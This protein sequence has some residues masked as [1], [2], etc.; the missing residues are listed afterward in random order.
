MCSFYY[1]FFC[2]LFRGSLAYICGHLHTLGG[3]VPRMYGRPVEGHLELEVGDW[4]ENR[5]LV[6]LSFLLF[7]I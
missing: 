6:S 2:L 5:V 3:L 1:F 4:K 7:L